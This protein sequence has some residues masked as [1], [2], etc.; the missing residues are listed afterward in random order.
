M[1]A[2]VANGACE[3]HRAAFFPGLEGT[4]AAFPAAAD[5]R[6][7][8]AACGRDGAAA[9]GDGAAVAAVI[10]GVPAAAD[11][12]AVKSAVGGDGTSV[13]VDDTAVAFISIAVLAGS[14]ADARGV[15]SAIGG[16]G[17][18]V[19]GDDTA[20]IASMAAADARAVSSACGRDGASVD[21]DDATGALVTAAD[22]RAAFDAVGGDDTAVDGDGPGVVADQAADGRATCALC[23]IPG[24][25]RADI[26]GH[27]AVRVQNGLRLPV[28]GQGVAIVLHPNAVVDREGAAVRQNQTDIAGND[29]STVDGHFS[30]CH[31]PGGCSFGAPVDDVFGHFRGVGADLLCAVFVQIGHVVVRQRR[32]GQKTHQHTGDQQDA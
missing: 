31:I 16:D 6:G 23:I 7:I 19:D 12:R 3:Y 26:V 17:A 28:D 4:A 11:A 14:A 10:T 22:A 5:A 2:R 20:V 18:S 30:P 9:D 25:Q 13:D 32:R 27:L 1:I 8:A 15:S 29:D 21:G 24:G